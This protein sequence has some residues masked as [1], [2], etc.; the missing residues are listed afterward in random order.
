MPVNWI[1]ANGGNAS[2]LSDLM[3]KTLDNKCPLVVPIKVSDRRLPA[4]KSLV[5]PNQIINVRPK[6][7]APR[8]VRIVFVVDH[9]KTLGK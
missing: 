3:A 4:N 7:I 2:W 1:Y 6:T 9:W 8:R 5:A